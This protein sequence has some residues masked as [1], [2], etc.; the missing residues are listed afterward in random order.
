L[1][2]EFV[3]T[4]GVRGRA[5]REQFAGAT[6]ELLQR[7]ADPK[8]ADLIRASMR[9][10]VAEEL[11]TNLEA[12]LAKLPSEQAAFFRYAFAVSPAVRERLLEVVLGLVETNGAAM[13][14]SLV[15][16]DAL[17]SMLNDA[18]RSGQIR[19]LDKLFASGTSVPERFRP[20]RWRVV[21]FPARTLILGDSC[22][23]GVGSDGATG[24]WLRTSGDGGWD[25]WQQVYLPISH[26]TV[27]I[28][29]NGT[30]STT[31]EPSEINRASAELATNQLFASEA[32]ESA[33]A[34][35][36][37][38]GLRDMPLDNAQLEQLV[39]DTWKGLSDG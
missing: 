21:H 3:W 23:I 7:S 38:I 18:A 22:L 11:G 9:K 36:E 13:F 28:A 5:T 34:L 35:A 17:P 39:S 4:L 6:L 15:H 25:S 10:L 8:N 16:T 24:T 12:V 29:E 31:L 19:G 14:H 37:C 1:L 26:D 32:S 30:L 2:R 33:R 20:V 27:L